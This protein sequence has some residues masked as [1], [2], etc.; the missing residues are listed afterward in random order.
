M[1][2][3]MGMMLEIRRGVRAVEEA[4]R[5]RASGDRFPDP[6]R[7]GAHHRGEGAEF[8]S[9]EAALRAPD[10]VVGVGGG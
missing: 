8:R 5:G 9:A 4:V 2:H 6:E 1:A 7:I 10:V 3:L